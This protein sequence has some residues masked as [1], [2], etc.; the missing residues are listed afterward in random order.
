MKIRFLKRPFS[1]HFKTNWFLDFFQYH[2]QSTQANTEMKKRLFSKKKNKREFTYFKTS[3]NEVISHYLLPSFFIREPIFNE[4]IMSLE[5]EKGRSFPS[6]FEDIIETLEKHFGLDTEGIFRQC[7]KSLEV[8]NFKKLYNG[9]DKKTQT[10]VL[11]LPSIIFSHTLENLPKEKRIEALKASDRF[12]VAVLLK[13]YALK[14]KFNHFLI[15]TL[16]CLTQIPNRSP[17]PVT[18]DVAIRPVHLRGKEHKQERPNRELQA[19]SQRPS[20]NQSQRPQVLAA[21]PCQGFAPLQDK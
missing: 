21:L 3:L 12:T 19:F 4:Q 1:F 8:L 11:F 7:G 17:R 2:P 16:Y 9:K 18:H 20:P 10:I 6:I 5:C 14:K 13:Q 15:F